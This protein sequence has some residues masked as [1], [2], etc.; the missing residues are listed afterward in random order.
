MKTILVILFTLI[1]N[2]TYSQEI[3]SFQLQRHQFNRFLISNRIVNKIKRKRFVKD[4]EYEGKYLGKFMTKNGMHFHIINSSYVHLKSLHSD[5]EIFIYNKK[6][7]FIGY[8]NLS[9]NYQLP[10]RLVNNVLIFSSDNC[11]TKINLKR[12]IPRLI[13]IG[14]KKNIDCLNLQN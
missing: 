4:Y 14:C 1:S 7:E 6:K 12:G 11:I 9:T 13:C 10:I 5:N 8:Y 3:F 2:I